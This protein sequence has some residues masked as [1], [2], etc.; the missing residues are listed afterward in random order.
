MKK[1]LILS[2]ALF[3]SINYSCFNNNLVPTTGKE[4]VLKIT[5]KYYIKGSVTFPEIKG[6]KI[7]NTKKFSIK[8][9]A[10]TVAFNTSISLI[11]INTN[12]TITTG[13]TNSSNNFIINPDTSFIPSEGT[14]YILDARKR[15]YSTK[16]NIISMRTFIKWQ[17][18]TWVSI[19]TPTININEKTTALV[20]LFLD[21]LGVNHNIGTVDMSVPT[22]KI[23]AN[24]YFDS[25]QEELDYF[26][27]RNDL[28]NMV[29]AVLEQGDDPISKIKKQSDGN[30]KSESKVEYQGL[31]QKNRC[32]YCKFSQEELNSFSFV[33]KDLSYAD[34]SGLDLSNKDFS[35]SI[36]YKANLSKSI[37]NGT[38]LTN[39]DLTG[40]NFD[41]I[42]MDAAIINNTEF[43]NSSFIRA[44]IKNV[45]FS[46]ID[47]SNSKFQVNLTNV[48][49]TG[50]NLTNSDFSFITENR[51]DLVNKYFKTMIFD[52]TKLGGG[53]NNA[54]FEGVTFKNVTIANAFFTNA[55]FSKSL[56]LS[57][58]FDTCDFTNANLSNTKIIN[59]DF[60]SPNLFHMNSFLN[61]N[62]SNSSIIN[63]DF[64]NAT[65]INTNFYNTD[66][67]ESKF[68]KL[69]YYSSYY[70]PNEFNVNFHSANLEK[71]DL[72]KI[73]FPGIGNNLQPVNFTGAILRNKD[74]KGYTLS[75]ADFT[76][77]IFT[78]ADLTGANIN[79]IPGTRGPANFNGA[80]MYNMTW[81]DGT[82]RPKPPVLY[83]TSDLDGNREIYSL[84]A[85]EMPDSTGYP[86]FAVNPFNYNFFRKKLTV[87]STASVTPK[88]SPD[89]TKIVYVEQ[90]SSNDIYVMNVDGTNPT[91]LA[92]TPDDE[93][94]PEW[95]ADG[96][97]IIYTRD[98]TD[99]SNITNQVK[100]SDIFIMSSDGSGQRLLTN[101]N[102]VKKDREPSISPKNI[103]AF[104][105]E[106]TDKRQI[107]TM[108]FDG[109]RGNSIFSP[110]LKQ[111][112]DNTSNDFLPQYSRDGKRILYLSDKDSGNVNKPNLWIMNEDGTNKIKLTTENTISAYWS[113]DSNMIAYNINK[114]ISLNE[115]HIIK[116]DQQGNIVKKIQVTDPDIGT[117]YFTMEVRGWIL[118]LNNGID[119]FNNA[120]FYAVNSS[121]NKTDIYAYYFDYAGKYTAR[122]ILSSVAF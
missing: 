5:S 78:G 18:N 21:G 8:D 84:M 91:K 70:G 33:G 28:S 92:G 1:F 29:R 83:R 55:D 87:S 36:L 58:K 119:T 113:E 60:S 106:R 51:I 10:D 103:I 48:D 38:N 4:E 95:S 77:A 104:R 40:V 116:L 94:D 108:G 12:G 110:P 11:D 96:K 62:F 37:L 100:V 39:T 105:S 85:D 3:L 82:K 53:Y 67:S 2:L 88:L 66:L 109:D 47:F 98:T 19:T 23:I 73:N 44:D 16:N 72:S 102:R 59:A 65:L 57:G 89:G 121:S 71:V 26:K 97:N 61:T 81:V 90:G 41:D 25:Y 17:N 74:L 14:V 13:I 79:S 112:G 6:L 49:L 80:S 120:I 64:T 117:K 107:F 122:Q 20:T 76:G 52:N 68:D 27:I 50:I 35:N 86:K 30:Y 93:Y 43:S 45:D 31:L 111:L 69:Y 114:G 9:I 75:G 15:I 54:N 34:L 7:Q 118:G 101:S 46:N 99:T 24:K 32:K 63:S 115:V 56:L 22:G 42:K